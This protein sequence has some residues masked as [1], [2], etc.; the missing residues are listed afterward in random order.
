[1]CCTYKHTSSMFSYTHLMRSNFV[2]FLCN[3]ISTYVKSVFITRH[4][5]NKLIH[6][7]AYITVYRYT[8]VNNKIHKHLRFAAYNNK[9]PKPNLQFFFRLFSFSSSFFI[10]FNLNATADTINVLVVH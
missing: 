7:H 2:V 9:N 4:S 3:H 8:D 5:Q 1:M 6:T 10:L